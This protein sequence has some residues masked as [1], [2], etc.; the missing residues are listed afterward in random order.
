M[1]SNISLLKYRNVKKYLTFSTALAEN[2]ETTKSK[3]I[4]VEHLVIEYKDIWFT[5]DMWSIL[6]EGKAEVFM[7]EVTE[8]SNVTTLNILPGLIVDR[9]RV[10]FKWL[11]TPMVLR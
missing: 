1:F 10:V 11:P 8:S 5:C 2:K 9:R 4:I 6:S 7:L 3:Q